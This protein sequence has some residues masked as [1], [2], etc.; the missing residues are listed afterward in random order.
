MNQK[1]VKSF[2]QLETSVDG[3]RKNIVKSEARQRSKKKV[4]KSKLKCNDGGCNKINI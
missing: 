2:F 1:G 4:S 3:N